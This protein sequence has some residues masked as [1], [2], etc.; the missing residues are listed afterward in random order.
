MRKRKRKKKKDGR[1]R[2]MAMT[3]NSLTHSLLLLF[4]VSQ[5]SISFTSFFPLAFPSLATVS[6]V[7]SLFFIFLLYF[8]AP[9]LA[10]LVKY[11]VFN[12]LVGTPFDKL[13][14]WVGVSL[15]AD[16]YA[17]DAASAVDLARGLVA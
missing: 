11:E 9:A 8:T 6:A 2:R 12:V 17:A 4:L 7:I 10:V 13:P 14:A 1:W 3:I 16:G 5:S 15:G